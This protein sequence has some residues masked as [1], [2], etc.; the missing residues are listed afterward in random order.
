MKKIDWPDKRRTYLQ[1][2]AFALFVAALQYAFLP[3]R[4]FGPPLVYSFF[5]ASITWAIIDFG[6]DVITGSE[7]TG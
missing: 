2:L 4:S 1:V 3:E 5:I 7:E 6:R